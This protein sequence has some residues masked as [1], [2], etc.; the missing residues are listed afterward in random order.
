M[1]TDEEWEL[2]LLGG[3]ESLVVEKGGADGVGWG[4]DEGVYA[5]GV[6]GGGGRGGGVEGATAFEPNRP[7]TKRVAVLRGGASPG[8][9]SVESNDNSQNTM[10][11]TG[12]NNPP[13]GRR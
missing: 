12:R 6:L 7:P 9:P 13:L 11:S 1:A 8:K 5:D 10:N 2:V 3:L 4:L